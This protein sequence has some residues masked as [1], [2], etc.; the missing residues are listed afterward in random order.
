MFCISLLSF[1]FWPLCCPDVLAARLEEGIFSP[2]VLAARLEEG[3]F[4]PDVLA[5]RLEE[6]IFNK[7]SKSTMYRKYIIYSN[8]YVFFTM[9]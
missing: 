7:Q 6:G 3:I 1:Y 9:K 2:D 5:A 8:V 4:S